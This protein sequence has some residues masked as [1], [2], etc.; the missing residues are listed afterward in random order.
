MDVRAEI[1]YPDAS[2]DQVFALC[3]DREFRAEVCRATRAL[4]NDVSIEP[5]GDGTTTVTV[6]RTM[7]ADLP[8]F[9]KK[10]VGETI[11]VVQTETWGP[12]D[13]AGQRTAELEVSIAGQ[14]A[15]LTGTVSLIV[16]GDGVAEVIKGDLRVSIPFLGKK[17]EPEIAKGVLAAARAEERCGRTRLASPT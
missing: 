1:N 13:E 9:V 17:I 15:K 16:V 6:R 5:H 12:P 4:D 14:P 2:T 7:P 3:V 8:D 11:D 10:L